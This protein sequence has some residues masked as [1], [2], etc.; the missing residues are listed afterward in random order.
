M[1]DF[2][3]VRKILSLRKLTQSFFDAL[4]HQG[5]FSLHV[6]SLNERLKDFDSD[7][8]N[9]L[10]LL[11]G[12]FIPDVVTFPDHAFLK[13]AGVLAYLPLDS[14]MRKLTYLANQFESFLFQMIEQSRRIVIIA[15]TYGVLLTLRRLST[16]PVIQEGLLALHRKGPG[17]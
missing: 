17:V 2:N 3:G 11:E 10:P 9:S 1:N 5:F 14:P 15:S 12:R 16:D 13:E 8:I 6:E 4:H 7:I